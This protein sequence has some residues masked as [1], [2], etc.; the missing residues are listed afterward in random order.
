M[1]LDIEYVLVTPN[2]EPDG[3]LD[4]YT[5][6]LESS[7]ICVYNIEDLME[8]LNN[9]F[10]DNRAKPKIYIEDMFAFY[11]CYKDYILEHIDRTGGYFFTK[12]NHPNYFTMGKF[13]FVDPKKIDCKCLADVYDICE[14]RGIEKTYQIPDSFASEVNRNASA[15]MSKAWKT[16]IKIINE[17]TTDEV[18]KAMSIA[19]AGGDTDKLEGDYKESMFSF[20]ITSA[21]PFQLMT[22]EFPCTKIVKTPVRL[23]EKKHKDGMPYIATIKLT[24]VDCVGINNSIMKHWCT[25][26]VNAQWTKKGRLESADE[27]TLTMTSI[28]IDI[29]DMWYNYD[30]K[31]MIE[32]YHV[33]GFSKLPD[34]L[35][36]MIG[37][38]YRKKKDN[39]KYKRRLNMIYGCFCHDPLKENFRF[40]ED[41]REHDD[42]QLP[43]QIGVFC[44][45][46]ARQE[47]N[48]LLYKL[49]DWAMYW[50]T[51]CIKGLYDPYDYDD[52][53]SIV[54]EYNDSLPVVEDIPEIGRFKDEGVHNMHIFECKKYITFDDNWEHG[55]ATYAGV[56]T[57]AYKD[58]TEDTVFEDG[59]KTRVEINGKIKIIIRDATFYNDSVQINL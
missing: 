19:Y 28:D 39:K 6:I 33:Y 4:I 32:Y 15:I 24:N 14:E 52:V 23:F 2:A 17:E 56:T 38:A 13:K 27:I 10:T 37:E 26:S 12:E 21:Y 58:V 9:E 44:T 47:L 46:Y 11:Y 51:D 41:E 16:N 3:T 31:E 49:Q 18:K 54:Q 22:R 20:D 42:N 55:V 48:E 36:G 30:S 25:D 59:H 45:A 8:E 29:I 1:S 34:K 7:G 35:I 53:L 43:F 5:M 57:D 40:E 50:D